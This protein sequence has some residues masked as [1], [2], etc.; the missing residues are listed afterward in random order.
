[1]NAM[2]RIP[3]DPSYLV[4]DISQW[5][6]PIELNCQPNQMANTNA[7]SSEMSEFPKMKSI[8]DTITG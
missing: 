5:I 2:A 6:L 4:K 1:M 8:I 7:M 3:D